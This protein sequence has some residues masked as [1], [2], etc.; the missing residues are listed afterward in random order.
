MLIDFEY[1][2]ANGNI[3]QLVKRGRNG[4]S[5]EDGRIDN[6]IISRTHVQFITD[7][8]IFVRT[9]HDYR[10]YISSD[11]DLDLLPGFSTCPPTPITPLSTP[12]EFL[13]YNDMRFPV[14]RNY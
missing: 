7:L 3:P 5:V 12:C 11:H 10:P 2:I 6:D 13:P 9:H 4:I 1:E 14:R 8:C